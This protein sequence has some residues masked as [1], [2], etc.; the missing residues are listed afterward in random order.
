MSHGMF[1]TELVRPLA[2]PVAGPL[3]VGIDLRSSDYAVW[4]GVAGLM[5][6]LGF[7]GLLFV[8]VRGITGGGRARLPV[9]SRGTVTVVAHLLRPDAQ[10][11]ADRWLA[12]SAHGVLYV[13]GPQVRWHYDRRTGW[14]APAGVL[15][16]SA[17]RPGVDGPVSAGVDFCIGGTGEWS[18]GWRLILGGTEPQ[19]AARSLTTR[20]R[21]RRD[22]ALAEQLAAALIAQGAIDARGT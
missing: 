6:P 1:L 13:T 5:L 20:A 22:A 16:I 7:A 19:P 21:R 2:G 3:A 15:I 14:T 4:W 10:L 9:D 11:T 17:V 12:P 8:V 18:G